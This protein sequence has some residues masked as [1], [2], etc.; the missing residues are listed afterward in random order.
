MARR[1]ARF[2]TTVTAVIANCQLIDGIG[3]CI[4][5]SEVSKEEETYLKTTGPASY[6][7]ME[8]VC[9]QLLELLHYLEHKLQYKKRREIVV[10]RVRQLEEEGKL[11]QADYT[12]DNGVLTGEL[13][14]RID[15]KGTLGE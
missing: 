5:K 13:T 10:E 6:V 14:R 11:P 8:Q 12:F 2:Q 3:G 4:Q 15:S 9:T 1:M 7:Q